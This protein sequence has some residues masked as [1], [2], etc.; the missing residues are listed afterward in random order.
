MRDRTPQQLH[1][2][3]EERFHLLVDSVKEYAIYMLDDCGYVTSWNKG[4]ERIKGYTPQEIIGSHYSVFF[5][6]EDREA[7]KPERIL[8]IAKNEGRYQGVG[9]RVRKGGIR[10]S[11]DVVL[12]AL[13]G[14]DGSLRGYGKVTRDVT[15]RIRHEEEVEEAGKRKDDFL[16]V[17]AHELRNPLAPIMS[18][19]A[20]LDE[21]RS[22]PASAQEHLTVI[23][24]QAGHLKRLLADLL[25]IARTN[26]GQITIERGKVVLQ[27]ALALAV[28]MAK[29]TITAHEHRLSLDIPDEMI[30]VDGDLARLAQI[31]SNLLH[32]AAKFSDSG[33]DIWLTA[34]REGNEVVIIVGDRGFGIPAEAIPHLFEKF[35]R[36]ELP[37]GHAR[38]GMG[39][40]LSLASELVQLH[41]GSIE[42]RSEGLERGSEL[43]TKLPCA[44]EE[45]GPTV[46]IKTAPHISPQR[47]LVVD[48]NEDAGESLAAVLRLSDDEV[49]AVTSGDAAL[50][51][52]DS[53]RP[54]VIIIDIGMPKMNGNE[55]A[56]RVRGLPPFRGIRLVALSGYGQEQD[57]QRSKDAGFDAH[58]VKPVGMD[59]LRKAIIGKEVE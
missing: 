34:R 42:A 28:E 56:E 4:A 13:Y 18:R 40:G 14:A 1:E 3:S 26:T 6:P 55:L 35:Y 2:Q 5:T 8:A 58:L 53:F 9:T 31:F 52:L 51:V 15:D 17:L 50:T 21:D 39:V 32:N 38:D 44:F 57:R 45:E 16:A 12:T 10:F 23:Q 54:S 7:G 24:R 25:D 27:D 29:P 33:G 37:L 30:L 46:P 43:I 49:I 41:G 59:D 11:A 36:V 20:L 47:V 48:D 19:L 22:V